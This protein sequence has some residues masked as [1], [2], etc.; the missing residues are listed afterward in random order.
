MPDSKAIWIFTNQDDPCRGDTNQKSRIIMIKKDCQEND[1]AIHVLPLPKNSSEADEQS[2]F[3]QTILYNDLTAHYKRIED[4]RDS[5]TGAVDI[6]AFVERF[7]IG[8]KKRRK[9]M[10]VPLLL[11][12]WKER[13]HDPG[14]MLDLY[15]VVQVR[16]RPQKLSVHQEKNK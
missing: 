9:L 1:I 15:G 6:N 16:T 10:T 2:S 8:M 14:I 11:P 13:E 5:D 12:G 7:Q 3:D 4:A